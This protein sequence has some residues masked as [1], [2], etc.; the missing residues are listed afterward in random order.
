[1]V[2][3][4]NNTPWD[5]TY[6]NIIDFCHKENLPQS[7]KFL[8]FPFLDMILNYDFKFN[9]PNDKLNVCMLVSCSKEMLEAYLSMKKKPINEGNIIYFLL[10][11]GLM[12]YKFIVGISG[13][14]LSFS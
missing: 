14:L 11:Y 7:K 13:K 12:N 3:E 8:A 4:V 9:T 2:A 10:T 5:E 1:M 6:S